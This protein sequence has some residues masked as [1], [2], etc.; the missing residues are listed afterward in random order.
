KRQMLRNGAVEVSGSALS[1]LEKLVVTSDGHPNKDW[2]GKDAA[3][4]LRAAG[5]SAPEST[6]LVLVETD[7]MHP[8]VQL[9]L[10]MPVVPLAR[11]A[12][13]DEGIREAVKAE[14]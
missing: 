11:V 7:S 14:H 4:I 1:R 2:V 3:K 5:I 6:R 10:L 13:V 12:D 8:F 9:E